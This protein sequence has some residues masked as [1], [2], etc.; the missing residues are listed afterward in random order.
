MVARGRGEERAA[1]GVLR[2]YESSANPGGGARAQ[3]DQAAGGIPGG[4]ERE[5]GTGRRV[6]GKEGHPGR[7]PEAG[8]GLSATS[9]SPDPR[10]PLLGAS[11]CLGPTQRGI[12]RVGRVCEGRPGSRRPGALRAMG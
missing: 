2:G 3:V 11:W 9:R 10:P 7:V 4:K 5:W 6:P 12:R 8:G 1:E